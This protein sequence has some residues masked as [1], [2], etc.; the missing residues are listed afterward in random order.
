M[1]VLQSFNEVNK[2]LHLLQ[3]EYLVTSLF[4][5]QHSFSTS[6]EPASRVIEDGEGR[7]RGVEGRKAVKEGRN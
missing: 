3:A 5:E 4:I 1:V 7:E 6:T 2:R